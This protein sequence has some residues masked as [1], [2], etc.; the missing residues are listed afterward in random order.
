ML[1]RTIATCLKFLSKI[2]ASCKFYFGKKKSIR[3]MSRLD[4]RI[5]RDMGIHRSQ[6]PDLFD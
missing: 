4:D 1:H 2:T 5:L 3:Q 6:I